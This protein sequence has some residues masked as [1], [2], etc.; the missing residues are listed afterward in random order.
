M[1]SFMNSLSEAPLEVVGKK[2]YMPHHAVIHKEAKSTEFKVV[3]DCS[4]RG[5]NKGS[6][7]NDC[8]DPGPSLQ[9]KLWN[10][11]VHGRF[12]PMAVAGDLHKVLLQ[13]HI[14]EK[15]CDSLC[16]HW[17]RS[18][19]STEVETLR[20]T[21]ALFRLAPS[22]FLLVGVIEHHLES[23]REECPMTLNKIEHSLY[24]D[25]LIS[26]GATVSDA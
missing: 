5:G 6:L 17:L 25:D 1:P 8:L 21:R 10:V 13:V 11:L 14:R 9:N 24:V 12:Y 23:W 19:N 18:L 15:E 16:S 2:Y 20:F 4:A 26:G 3:Y 22:S 7:L